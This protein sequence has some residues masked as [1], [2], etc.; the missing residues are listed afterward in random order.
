MSLIDPRQRNL[1]EKTLQYKFEIIHIA[2][3]TN[4][5][6]DA[7]SIYPTENG[8]PMPLEAAISYQLRRRI[9]PNSNYNGVSEQY[10]ATSQ[11]IHQ[12]VMKFSPL[13]LLPWAPSG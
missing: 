10:G 1:E 12:L 7:V 8:E 11:Q 2:G 6:P 9:G 5:V 13:R 4:N 3:S